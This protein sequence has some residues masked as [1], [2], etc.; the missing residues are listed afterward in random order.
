[1]SRWRQSLKSDS[2]FQFGR[3]LKSEVVFLLKS[4]N[5]LYPHWS[6]YK[7]YIQ[8]LKGMRSSCLRLYGVASGAYRTSQLYT[9]CP[10]RISCF[11]SDSHSGGFVSLFRPS[12]WVL[13]G[14]D[15]L[16]R[17][18]L[19]ERWHAF[20]WEVMSLP[21]CPFFIMAPC[22]NRNPKLS[23]ERW[24]YSSFPSDGG[25]VRWQSRSVSLTG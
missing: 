24:F 21:S 11:W 8:S 13:P 23:K 12:H 10:V 22:R 25:F 5:S 3:K 15:I 2:P 1:M 19:N 9:G 20:P 16:D 17:F 7:E 14:T 6:E 4:K 18:Q